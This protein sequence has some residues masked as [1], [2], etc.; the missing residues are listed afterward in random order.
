MSLLAEW[1]DR[2]SIMCYDY[3]RT[4]TGIPIAPIDWVKASIASLATNNQVTH[5]HRSRHMQSHQRSEGLV[6]ALLCMGR[7]MLVVLV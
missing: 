6:L 1:V 4:Q 2:F 7:L 3:G 5:I